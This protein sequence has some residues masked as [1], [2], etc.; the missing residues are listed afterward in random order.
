MEKGLE[1][2]MV[3]IDTLEE[4]LS[5]LKRISKKISNW[6]AW[7]RS[8]I[9]PEDEYSDEFKTVL[10]KAQENLEMIRRTGSPHD[11][12]MWCSFCHKMLPCRFRPYQ[13][14]GPYWRCSECGEV[15]WEVKEN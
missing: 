7:R 15:I 4:H 2:V 14:A 13:E 12:D 8:G 6:P 3:K 1:I 10:E 5:F 9:V 11:Q